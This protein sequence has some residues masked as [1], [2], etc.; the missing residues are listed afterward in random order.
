[1][2]TLHRFVQII[3]WTMK[4]VIKIMVGREEEKAKGELEGRR[5]IPVFSRRF[6]SWFRFRKGFAAGS[7]F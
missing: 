7:E 4:N 5:G 6:R 1:M 2:P 3:V